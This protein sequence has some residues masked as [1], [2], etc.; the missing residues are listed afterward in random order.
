M[1]VKRAVRRVSISPSVAFEVV[2]EVL[3]SQDPNIQTSVSGRGVRSRKARSHGSSSAPGTSL[4]EERFVRSRVSG[5]KRP[6]W[7]RR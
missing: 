1:R 3:H 7:R 5:K 6:N 2:G 4:R